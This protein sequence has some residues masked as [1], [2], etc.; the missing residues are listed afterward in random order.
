MSYPE[1]PSTQYIDSS[2]FGKSDCST[3]L[4]KHMLTKYLVDLG[5]IF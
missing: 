5:N 3:G 2:D 1:G 4:G